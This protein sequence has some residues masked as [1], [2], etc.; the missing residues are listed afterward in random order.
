MKNRVILVLTL[1]FLVVSASF[2]SAETRQSEFAM[3]K[4]SVSPVYSWGKNGIITVPKATT[5]GKWNVFLGGSV[6]EAGKIEG[7]SLYLSSGSLMV[8][9]SSD[10]ELGY[11][12]RQFI[13]DDFDKT[14]I[15]MDSYHFKARVFKMADYFIPQAAVG[16]NA[17]SLN[18]SDFSS[19]D[20]I[21]FNP[22]LSVTVQIPV[23]K[24]KVVFSATGVVETLY[25][26][27]ETSSDFFSGGADIGIYD[28]FYLVAEAQGLNKDDEDPLI[29][30]GAK[31]KHGWFSFGIAM[32]N[33]F[34]DNISEDHTKNNEDSSYFKA[35]AAIE[36]PFGDMFK[37]E[38][39]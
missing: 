26:E 28:T 11:T 8:G 36:I 15:E 27:G 19:K 20:E 5:I 1:V 12:K 34:Q 22:Y 37:K 33:A 39:K 6:Q 21:L 14:D 16:I 35:N 9:T 31:V 10:V 30:L 23:Y 17:V 13:W 2:V 3:F 24:D 29:N 7:D 38:D 18:G 25:N 32:Y 4:R